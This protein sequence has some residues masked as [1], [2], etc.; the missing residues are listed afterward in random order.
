MVIIFLVCLNEYIRNSLKMQAIQIP[1]NY[2]CS[3]DFLEVRKHF[4]I[5]NHDWGE[6]TAGK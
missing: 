2:K 1:A 5:R 4:R 6:P 3:E